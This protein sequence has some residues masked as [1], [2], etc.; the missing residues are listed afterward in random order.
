MTVDELLQPILKTIVPLKMDDSRK[1]IQ[2]W[3]SLAQ[4]NMVQAIEDTVGEELSTAEVLSLKTVAKVIEVC[5][6]HGVELT[7]S[8][9]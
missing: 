6:A 7:V 8:P 1:T 5:R 9:D 3:D 4:I 2:T